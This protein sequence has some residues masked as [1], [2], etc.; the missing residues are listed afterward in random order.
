MATATEFDVDQ[1]ADAVV[2]LAMSA[3]AHPP[4]DRDGRDKLRTSIQD[5]VD[6]LVD[7]CRDYYKEAK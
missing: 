4:L 6:A 2:D 1:K 5:A 3:A 7:V